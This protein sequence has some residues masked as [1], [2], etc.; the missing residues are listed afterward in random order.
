MNDKGPLINRITWTE[1]A[2]ASTAVI[3]RLYTR[4]FVIHSVGL[5]DWV[6]LFALV[7]GC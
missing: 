1:T 4:I 6:M 5:D 7:S 2:L 3:V